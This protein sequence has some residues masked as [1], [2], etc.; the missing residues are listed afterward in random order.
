MADAIELIRNERKRQIEAEGWSSEH[1]DAHADGELMDAGMCYFLHATGRA[2][3]RNVVVGQQQNWRI[4]TRRSVEPV[5]VSIPIA[6][7]WEQRWWKPGSPIRNLEK[8]GGLFLAEKD[9]L[10]RAGLPFHHVDHKLG[11]VIEALDRLLAE[12]PARPASPDVGGTAE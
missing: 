2:S 1:D 6:W 3:Y 5:T 10:Q 11:L 7:P 4:R 9:R 12:K 8:A